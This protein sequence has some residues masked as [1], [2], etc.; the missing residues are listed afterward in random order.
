MFDQNDFLSLPGHAKSELDYPPFFAKNLGGVI[1]FWAFSG[2]SSFQAENLL[3]NISVS[4][5]FFSSF[6]DL[7]QKGHI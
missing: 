6:F 3:Q 7:A 2:A 1:T 4:H 5:M